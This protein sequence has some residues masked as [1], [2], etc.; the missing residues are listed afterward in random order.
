MVTKQKLRQREV[1][2]VLLEIK[3]LKSF[4]A[5]TASVV[6]V[7]LFLKGVRFLSQFNMLGQ[8]LGRLPKNIG[9][10]PDREIKFRFEVI[11]LGISTQKC[12]KSR[13]FR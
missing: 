5:C 6:C 1:C 12:R 4:V 7:L 2:E 3:A 11:A 8:R 9:S 10:V 13:T